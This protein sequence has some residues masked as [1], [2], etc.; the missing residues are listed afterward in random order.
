MRCVSLL[1]IQRG[2]AYSVDAKTK[3]K[4]SEFFHRQESELGHA[5]PNVLI[6]FFFFSVSPTPVPE[7]E[8]TETKKM[9]YY[10]ATIMKIRI[11]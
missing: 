10:I 8:L 2:R 3:K 7:G 4:K 1:E 5:I 9:T 6:F 11:Q